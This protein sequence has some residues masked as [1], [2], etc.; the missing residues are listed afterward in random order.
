MDRRDPGLDLTRTL[1]AS[2]CGPMAPK[3]APLRSTA[4]LEAIIE[5]A[6]V[7]LIVSDRAGIM[8][9][10]NRE[11]EIMFAYTRDELIGASID[12]LLPAALR[13]G[14]P[15]L[16]ASFLARPI[17]RKMGQGRALS[18]MRSNGTMVPIEV[19]LTPI[20]LDDQLYVL[21]VIA[22]VTERQRLL[23]EV[24]TAKEALEVRVHERTLALE[25]ANAE[26]EVL[27]ANLRQQGLELERLSRQDPLTRLSN[28][29]DQ[30]T[31]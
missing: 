15:A 3:V 29:R 2:E 18:G 31:L 7:A 19:G 22:D 6:P 9:L 21:S 1:A 25:H 16:R 4:L 11:A 20:M 24:T 28:R 26:M 23:D 5:S 17:D 30:G 8:T 27:L 10:V 14:H 12:L 13:H